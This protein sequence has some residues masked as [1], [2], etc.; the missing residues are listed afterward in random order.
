MIVLNEL[1]S[2]LACYA[3]DLFFQTYVYLSV[4]ELNHI[5]CIYF[6]STQ[7]LLMYII[8]TKCG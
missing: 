7:P 1:R 4:T 8:S 6:D 2:E 3:T 5:F